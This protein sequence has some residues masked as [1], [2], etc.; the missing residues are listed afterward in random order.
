MIQLTLQKI[1]HDLWAWHVNSMQG[2]VWGNSGKSPFVVLKSI[3][4]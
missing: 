3:V 4:P 2:S 1:K